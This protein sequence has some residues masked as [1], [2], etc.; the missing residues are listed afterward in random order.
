MI[1]CLVELRSDRLE[2]KLRLVLAGLSSSHKR[3]FQVTGMSPICDSAA[4]TGDAI[5]SLELTG[6]KI[7][8]VVLEAE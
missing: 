8:H 5:K 2:K 7:E 1:A 3:V 6:A 4:T